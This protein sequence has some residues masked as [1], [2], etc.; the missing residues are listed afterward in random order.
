MQK[1]HSLLL[2]G[3]V[4]YVPWLTRAVQKGGASSETKWNFKLNSVSSCQK[5]KDSNYLRVLM[6]M[7]IIIENDK[8]ICIRGHIHIC[9]YIY[10]Y[11]ID[12]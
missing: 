4:V 7:T 11:I 12:T 1:S 9:I 5:E 2:F 10:T 6:L 3:H 8:N